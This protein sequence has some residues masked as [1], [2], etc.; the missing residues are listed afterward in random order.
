MGDRTSILIR[1]KLN[2][3]EI[4]TR[5][6]VPLKGNI[7]L[8][9]AVTT[10]RVPQWLTSSRQRLPGYLSGSVVLL[11]RGRGRLRMLCRLLR[12]LSLKRRIEFPVKQAYNGLG[13]IS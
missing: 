1:V 7:P 12:A 6:T 9:K 13:L 10:S 8:N 2:A 5:L 3:N 11:L 4:L